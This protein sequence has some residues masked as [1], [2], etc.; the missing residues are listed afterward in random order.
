MVFLNQIGGGQLPD[1][2]TYKK[3]Q[4]VFTFSLLNAENNQIHSKILSL[5]KDINALKA[6][7][8][9]KRI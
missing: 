5:A 8:A 7:S 9:K 3:V 4:T 6:I 2:R 1:K